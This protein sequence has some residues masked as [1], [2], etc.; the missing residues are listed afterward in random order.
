MPLLPLTPV[1]VS[2]WKRRRALIGFLTACAVAMF[3]W[4]T[5]LG[6]AVTS[7]LRWLLH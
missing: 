4:L 5:G 6:W 2:R 3:G 1:G 7:V